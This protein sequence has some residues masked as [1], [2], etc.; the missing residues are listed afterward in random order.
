MIRSVRK[1]VPP[2]LP[3]FYK[4]Q[5]GR[6]L[7]VGGSED[8]TGAPYFAAMA[9]ALVGCDMSHILCTAGAAPVIKSYSPNLMVHPYLSETTPDLS[10]KVE[11]LLNRV[12]VVLIGPGLGRD[13]LVFSQI[14]QIL[15][16]TKSRKLPLVIDADGL[17]LVQQDLTVVESYLPNKIILTPN[18]VEFQRL[19]TAAKLPADLSRT[20]KAQKLAEQLRC[21]LLVKGPEDVI[22]DGHDVEVNATE[23]SSRRVSGQGDTLSGAV[24]TFVAWSEAY[25]ENLWETEPIDENLHIVAAWGASSVA[26]TASKLAYAACGRAMGTTDVNS[27]V[28]EAFA[29]LFERARM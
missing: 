7:V 19:V 28:G 5:L 27:R 10:S 2:L 13:P 6:V 23:G 22:T 26:R 14:R 8:Y 16:L 12:H 11:P 9:A 4:G 17:F 21:T 1:L 24:A 18:V 25:K 15:E 3:Q 29:R 20:E